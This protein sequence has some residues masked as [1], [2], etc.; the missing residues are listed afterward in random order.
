MD[1]RFNNEYCVV[2]D[3]SGKTILAQKL[4]GR[5]ESGY[6]I[7]KYTDITKIPI[8]KLPVLKVGEVQEDDKLYSI[9]GK[10]SIIDT[11]PIEIKEIEPIIKL[12][13]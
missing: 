4:T 9:A 1:V 5:V 6:T 2:T 10:V 12:T 7:T 8:A 3:K 13:K 11:K